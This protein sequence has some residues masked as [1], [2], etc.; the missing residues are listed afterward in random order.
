VTTKADARAAI[1]AA[2]AARSGPERAA[3]RDA[4]RAEVLDW[5]VRNGLAAG[6]V[7]A[8]YEPL[9]TEPGSTELL[10]ALRA[11]GF[12]VI[13]PRTQPDRDLDWAPWP[14]GHQLLG[15]AAIGT[16]SLVLVPAFA[17]SRDGDRLGRGGGSYDRAL[18]R[19]PPGIPVAA[20]I[21]SD[22][23]LDAVP[24]DSWDRPVTAAVSPD[25]W[26]DFTPG[27]RRNSP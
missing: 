27:G 5:C 20:L 22:E 17:V 14:D 13:V 24:I 25:G 21:Y 19:V 16:T 11:E 12:D 18:A 6:S 3:A 8:A 23:L 10:V 7:V 4:V 26:L 2:R 15:L 1:S 9:R